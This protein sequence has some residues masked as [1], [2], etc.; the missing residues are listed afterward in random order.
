MLASCDERVVAED[1]GLERVVKVL[2]RREG[3]T[4]T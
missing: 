4:G 1:G 2:G 3:T